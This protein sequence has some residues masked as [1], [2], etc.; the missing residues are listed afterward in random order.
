MNKIL[1]LTLLLASACTN[2]TTLR[3]NAD[4]ANSGNKNYSVALLPPEAEIEYMQ[5]NADNTRMSNEENK[6]IAV[7]INGAPKILASKGYTFAP[8]PTKH[9]DNAFQLERVR[10]EIKTAMK[11]M[12][13]TA[14]INQ[15]EAFKTNKTIGPD[16]NLFADLTK[17]DLLLYIDYEGYEKS[18]AL[19]T[20]DI[21]GDIFLGILTAGASVTP[22]QAGLAKLAL[23]DGTT[24]DVLWANEVY[25][26]KPL[27]KYDNGDAAKAVAIILDA[28]PNKSGSKPQD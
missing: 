23:I 7:I 9:P 26:S 5:F 14:K 12:Y 1:I 19:A 25:L 27:N 17:A 20:K 24:G 15:D 11:E 3:E 10:Q 22:N 13:K 8:F 4:F 21:P 6:V 16:V 28:L 2:E 18:T